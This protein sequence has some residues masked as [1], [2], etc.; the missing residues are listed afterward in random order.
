[1]HSGLQERFLDRL[2]I[3]SVFETRGAERFKIVEE[4]LEDA[5]LKKFYKMLW[6]SEA[7]HGNIY[8]K[9]ALNYFDKKKVYQRLN[10]WLDQE[11]EVITS[12][13]IRAALH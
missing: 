5:E 9:M 3:G 10:W 12:L 2:L 7:R 4:N 1:M 13:P 6:T 8:V 11:A